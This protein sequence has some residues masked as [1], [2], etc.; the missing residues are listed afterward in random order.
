MPEVVTT[1]V[2]L[3]PDQL[4]RLD[5]I[6]QSRRSKRS[7]VVREIVERGLTLIERAEN[8][9]GNATGSD[10]PQTETDAA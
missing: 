1:S 3:Y 6:A 10:D 9:G 5:K 2:I 7:A 8:T 4:D